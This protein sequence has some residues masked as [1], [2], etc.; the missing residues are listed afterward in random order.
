MIEFFSTLSSY[1]DKIVTF[2]DTLFTNVK[3]SI[4]E[5]KIWIGYLPTPL[6]ASAAIIIVLIV[7][8]K[9]LGRG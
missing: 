4:A 9:V 6:I 8:Y 2:F 1:I 3:Q 7:I 5:I